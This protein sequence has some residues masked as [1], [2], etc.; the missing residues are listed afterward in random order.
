[1][2]KETAKAKAKANTDS[3]GNPKI[4]QSEVPALLVVI[5]GQIKD[6]K[7]VEPGAL[8]TQGHEFYPYGAV[9]HLD[10]REKI[11]AAIGHVMA[12]EKKHNAAA[13]LVPGKA[14]AFKLGSGTASKFSASDWIDSLKTQY[15][16]I[17]YDTQLA[18]FEKA[19]AALTAE[20]SEE[21]K[22]SKRLLEKPMGNTHRLFYF[23]PKHYENIN[24]W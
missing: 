18:K 17:D 10:T 2:A 15:A 22:I 20:L 19:K 11:L 21:D 4:D 1:M 7:Q 5:D 24:C 16:R 23:K 12:E 13:K 9:E 14:P 6:L 8:K 3:A